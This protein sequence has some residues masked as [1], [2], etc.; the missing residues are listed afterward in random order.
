MWMQIV[1]WAAQLK[2]SSPWGFRGLGNNK[3]NEEIQDAQHAMQLVGWAPFCHFRVSQLPAHA[4]PSERLLMTVDLHP[5][6]TVAMTHESHTLH[7]ICH[8]NYFHFHITIYFFPPT[9][10]MNLH[11]RQI[12]RPWLSSMRRPAAHV[13]LFQRAASAN[14]IPPSLNP[15]I[16]ISQIEL[17]GETKRLMRTGWEKK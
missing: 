14:L 11:L 15:S 2:K 8:F 6:S 17:A 13:S 5:G 1:D 10:Q 4:E 7:P 16:L 3:R 12:A 9:M